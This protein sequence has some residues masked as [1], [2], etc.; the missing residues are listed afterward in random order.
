MDFIP[1]NW[2]GVNIRCIYSV[3]PL[4]ERIFLHNVQFYK[5]RRVSVRYRD[6]VYKHKLQILCLNLLESKRAFLIG[7][8]DLIGRCRFFIR[9][10]NVGRVFECN[11]M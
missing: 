2:T 7:R 11:E 1:L 10:R 5:A 9:N 4:I 3:R 8:L 6:S